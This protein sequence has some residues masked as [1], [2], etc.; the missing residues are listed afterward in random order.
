MLCAGGMWK[1]REYGA[2]IS[3]GVGEVINGDM[4]SENVRVLII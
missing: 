1:N 2:L 3:G 4:A